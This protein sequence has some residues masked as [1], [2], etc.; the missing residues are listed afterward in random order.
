MLLGS[1]RHRLAIHSARAAWCEASSGVMRPSSIAGTQSQDPTEG[2][3][4]MSLAAL[5]L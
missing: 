5:V 1:H 4:E 2:S 3:V